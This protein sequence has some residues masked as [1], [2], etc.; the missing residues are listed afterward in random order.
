MYYTF[1]I[2]FLKGNAVHYAITCLQKYHCFLH[3][4]VITFLLR[5][6]CTKHNIKVTKNWEFFGSVQEEKVFLFCFVY[7]SLP[8]CPADDLRVQKR[9]H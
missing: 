1:L 6:L 2:T 7:L 8:T 3:Y 5:M 4:F 9:T